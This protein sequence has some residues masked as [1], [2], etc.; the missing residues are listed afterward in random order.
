M[1]R[2]DR[3]EKRHAVHVRQSIV[4]DDTVNVG[5]LQS[6]KPVRCRRLHDDRKAPVL[7][8]KKPF[9]DVSELRIVVSLQNTYCAAVL[10]ADLFWSDTV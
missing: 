8:L 2:T 6:R 3:F 4:R 7:A 10:R 9:R 5:L 1:V